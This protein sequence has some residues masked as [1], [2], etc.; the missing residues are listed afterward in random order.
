MWVSGV[1]VRAAA[2]EVEARLISPWLVEQASQHSDGVVVTHV[3]KVDVVHLTTK[4]PSVPADT[5]VS[6][7]LYL[8]QHVSRL[9]ASV[10]CH[11]SA[12]HDGADVDA[13]ITPVRALTNNTDAQE[14]E[15]L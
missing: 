10:C 7:R 9:D 15:P 3:L 1:G 5:G 6:Q 11:R 2:E 14:V 8:Q 4:S 13:S 12:L